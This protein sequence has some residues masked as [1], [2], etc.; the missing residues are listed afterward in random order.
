MRYTRR[1]NKKTNARGEEQK[2]NTPA[3]K[4]PEL[5]EAMN[6]F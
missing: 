5:P 2:K 1:K 4:G 6:V 3:A